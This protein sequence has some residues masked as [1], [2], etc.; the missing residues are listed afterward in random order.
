MKKIFTLL[1]AMGSLTAVFAQS[2]HNDNHRSVTSRSALIAPTVEHH[3]SSYTNRQVQPMPRIKPDFGKKI[4][5]DVFAQSKEKKM[6][7]KEM[8]RKQQIML[9]HQKFAKKSWNDGRR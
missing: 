8:Q 4:H 3:S 2:G 9:A 6:R 1:L 7:I 5:K